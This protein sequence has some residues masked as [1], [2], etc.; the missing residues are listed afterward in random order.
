MKH[1]RVRE[2]GAPEVMRLEEGQ[3]P[4]AGP[5]QVVVRVKAAGVNPVDTYVRGGLFG[6]KPELPYT[7]GADAAGVVES[8]GAGVTHV[9]VG[10]RVYGARSISGAYAEQALFDALH[11][12][13][14]PERITFSQGACIGI[15]YV[16]AYGALFLRAKVQPGETIL[17]HGASGGVGTAVL[18]LARRLQATIIGTAGS[19]EGRRLVKEQGAAFVLD[20]HDP[21]HVEEILRLTKGRGVDVIDRRRFGGDALGF[22]DHILGVAAVVPVKQSIDLVA[23]VQAGHL[24]TDVLDHAGDIAAKGER[25]RHAD[26][27]ELARARLVIAGTGN[28]PPARDPDRPGAC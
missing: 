13:P 10:D 16:T 2:L 11:V 25:Q 17:I 26:L 14:L 20:H 19:E 1:I 7:P 22:C 4:T 18:Q 27:L 12:Q 15:P 23:H 9:A 6:Y 21:G 8:V 3:E 5:G 28:F 24:A